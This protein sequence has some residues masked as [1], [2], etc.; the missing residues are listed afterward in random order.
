MKKFTYLDN[1]NLFET[2]NQKVVKNKP[3]ILAEI[4][5]ETIL[6]VDKLFKEKTGIDVIK[7]PLIGCQISY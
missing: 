6:E 7:N 3:V 2:V 4:E 5:A 1:T